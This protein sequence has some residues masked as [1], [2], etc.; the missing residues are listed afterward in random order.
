VLI[1][2]LVP[3]P[4]IQYAFNVLPFAGQAWISTTYLLGLLLVLL[5]GARWESVSPGQLA[6]GLFFAIGAASVLSVG[7]QL[8]QW[9]GL[10]GLETLSMDLSGTRPYANLGQPNQLG[11]LLLWG[12]LACAW[13]VVSGRVRGSV[14]ILMASYLLFGI[15]LTQSRT[16]W[17]GLSLILCAAWFW[18]KLWP[19]KWIPLVVTV[20]GFYFVI[21]S[22]A[23]PWMTDAL[24]LVDASSFGES[25]QERMSGELRPAAWRMFIDAALQRPWFGYGWTAVAQA[26]LAVA[27]DHPSL[28]VMFGHAHNLFIDL[29]LWSGL[30]VG[31]LTLVSLLYWFAMCFR[32]IASIQEA[33]LLMF[34]TVVGNHAMLE[35]P[36]HYAYFLL[37]TGIVIGVLNARLGLRPVLRTPRWMLGV[38][39]A[40]A[41][42][43]LSCSIRDY[44]MVEA[45]FN[46]L[47]FER[48]HVGTLPPGTPPDVLLLTQ[49]KEQLR[50]GRFEPKADMND[51]EIEWVRNVTMGSPGVSELYKLAIA[52]AL[53]RRPDEG[54]STL[55][56]LCKV[57]AVEQCAMVSRVWAQRSLNEPGIAAVPWPN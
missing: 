14:A 57:A 45:N 2:A 49:L 4:L 38:I 21:C 25:F 10:N 39:W 52:L 6:G 29:V 56:K 46:A 19:S 48:A 32:R 36:L 33:I 35:L 27:S 41:A 17:I 24:Q 55:K 44:F 37:P 26:Q 11:T 47:R 34:V 16:A 31:L 43:L 30:P 50:F 40:A 9:L 18:R 3:V 51:Q 22:L 12:L 42:V 23:L 20:L 1:A 15:A 53:N 13:G 7:L 28:G 54:Q 5:T 8:Y